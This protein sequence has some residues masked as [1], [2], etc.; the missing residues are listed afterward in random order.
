M[1]PQ[2]LFTNSNAAI[3][4]LPQLEATVDLD[5]LLSL[6]KTIRATRQLSSMK[7]SGSDR[8]PAEIYNRKCNRQLCDNR[9]G[10][11]LLNIVGELSARIL[12]CNHLE[13][14]RLLENQCGLRR[15][16]GTTDMIFTALQLQKKRQEMRIHFCSA[17]VNL[18][19][20]FDTI[21]AGVADNGAISE[22]FV[23]TNAV[24]QGC[25]LTPTFFSLMF[26]AM[27]LDACGDERSGY[28]SPTELADI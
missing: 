21:M 24:K 3:A 11:L 1:R 2:S 19:N 9:R 28:A 25:A 5:L 18:T 16:H 20:A 8:I 6:H 23:V 27:L 17:F 14:N 7:A 15:H 10:I 22:A 12:L 4:R 26:S 13:Q